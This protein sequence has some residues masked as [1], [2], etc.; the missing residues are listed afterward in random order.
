MSDSKVTNVDLPVVKGVITQLGALSTSVGHLST[1][2][3][4]GSDLTWT[5]VDKTG[6]TLHDQ[7]VPAEQGGVQAVTDVKGAVEGVI[8]SLGTTVG[9]WKNTEGTNLGLNQ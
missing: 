6:T 2:M 7:L 1:L 9:L 8:G 5:G 3:Q 4:D